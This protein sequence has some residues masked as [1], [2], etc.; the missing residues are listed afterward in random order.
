MI[1]RLSIVISLTLAVFF[2]SDLNAE[3]KY[4]TH[5]EVQYK[6]DLTSILNS[7]P[8]PLS[9]ITIFTWLDYSEDG[10]RQAGENGFQ[11]ITLQLYNEF[12]NLVAS[13]ITGPDGNYVFNLIPNGKYR[14]KFNKFAGLTYTHQTKGCLL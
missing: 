13:G 10:I 8:A 11:G 9:S 12:N 14:V 6:D 2:Y 1:H 3:G 4:K 7:P 5:T